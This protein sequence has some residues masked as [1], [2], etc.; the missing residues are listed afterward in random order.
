MP[1]RKLMNINWT[2]IWT[3]PFCSLVLLLTSCSSLR[4]Q[5]P[6]DLFGD[7]SLAGWKAVLTDPGVNMGQVWSL[8]GGV[9][10][11]QGTP[12]GVLFKGPEV[13]DFR[14]SVDYRWAPGTTPG[15]S[16]IFSRIT[17]PVTPLP[18][19]VEVQLANGNAGDVLGLQ[20]RKVEADQPRHFEVKGHKLAG[21]ISGVRKLQGAEAPAG[22]W[23]HVEI[24]AR[25][26]RY[27]VTINGQLVNEVNGVEVVRGAI[28]LQ[29][30]GGVIQ[31]RRV[32]LTRL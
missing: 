3:V 24:E 10:T 19:A 23:N 30:E 13:T 22:E 5:G 27:T 12:I 15:N 31:F 29:S 28:G 17:E 14:L 11:C 6:V 7:D 26:P 4:E 1:K 20:G 9:L 21:D 16:G 18:K 8:E 2:R 32:F 25:G